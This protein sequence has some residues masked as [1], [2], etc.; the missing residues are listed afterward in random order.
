MARRLNFTKRQRIRH[1]DVY[2]RLCGPSLKQFDMELQLES[3]KLD[4][5]AD[6]L[7]E[8][9]HRSQCIRF[10]WGKAGLL[11]PPSVAT[12]EAFED[13]EVVKFRVKIVTNDE[14]LLIAIA[15]KIRPRDGQSGGRRSLLAVESIRGLG[16]IWRLDYGEVPVLQIGR[17]FGLKEEIVQAPEFRALVLPYILR[18]ILTKITQ[19]QSRGLDDYDEGEWQYDWI[20]LG[21]SIESIDDTTASARENWI[22]G[23]VR[24]FVRNGRLFDQYL[25]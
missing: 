7:V 3:Y 13:P 8:A 14:R 25:R 4:H 22:E 12:L 6:V 17:E 9:Y 15:D 21:I 20:K 5:N 11:Q 16:E 2:V 10:Q 1:S 19:D 23:V 24:G 18:D